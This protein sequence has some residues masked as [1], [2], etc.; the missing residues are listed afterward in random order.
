MNFSEFYN[1]RLFLEKQL[2]YNIPEDKEKLMYDFYTLSY[3]SQ[4]NLLNNVGPKV[5]GVGEIM[6]T[7]TMRRQLDSDTVE[8]FA[9]IKK[10]ILQYLKKHMLKAVSFA[11]S[12]EFR[13]IFANN[14][15][16]KIISFFEERNA[17]S[18]IREYALN[19]K[20]LNTNF[21]D[22]IKV[23]NKHRLQ[24]FEHD[25]RGYLDSY[26]AITQTDIRPSEFV[27]LAEDSFTK[28]A[29]SLSYGGKA[30]AS[31]CEGWLRLFNAENENALFVAIDHIYDLQHNTDTVFNKL[32]S[33]YKQSGG[34]SWI[35]TALDHKANLKNPYDLLEKGSGTI[36][37]LAKKILKSEGFES[38]EGYLRGKGILAKK[39]T[40][41]NNN[42]K[43]FAEWEVGDIIKC[44]D[45][46]LASSLQKGKEYKITWTETV[47]GDEYVHIV[48]S[49]TTVWLARRFE[50]V[51]DGKSVESDKDSST[52]KIKV[53]DIVKAKSAQDYK[54]M[55]ADVN[56]TF[57]VTK[58]SSIADETYLTFKGKKSNKSFS[59][60]GDWRFE[61]VEQK[62][63]SEELFKVGEVYI[64][65]NM[66]P[67]NKNYYIL[68]KINNSSQKIY[69]F[70]LYTLDGEDMGTFNL[71]FRDAKRTML[72]APS[73][74]QVF[75]LKKKKQNSQYKTGD[76]LVLKKEKDLMNSYI[77][78]IAGIEPAN[79]M[80]KVELRNPSGTLCGETYLD[81]I[82]IS[83]SYNYAS[84]DHDYFK[85]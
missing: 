79:G 46:K 3:L 42:S 17:G 40:K 77:Y 24:R 6:N 52:D 18:F 78:I 70:T 41:N 49:G 57:I 37:I 83:Q 20:A 65:K 48:V 8:N 31:I 60:W 7:S 13:H 74:H 28:L 63:K 16:D 55:E 44:R 85:I 36:R 32:K 25:Q 68:K 62:R 56:E 15:N 4:F 10:T 43:P 80:Y 45:A 27:K 75:R 33:Y 19:Y 22:F 84:P 11:I 29:W 72:P 5:S 71:S 64:H 59:G 61:K 66:P 9:D 47:E 58:V 51:S 1:N 38:W 30:W 35:K 39:K 53:G 21:G 54:D 69:V 50:W 81:D 2:S 76:V 26:T 82:E 23:K 34:Y 12:A 14:N 73:N 67:S